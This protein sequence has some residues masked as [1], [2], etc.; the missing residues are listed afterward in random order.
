MSA[1]EK[2]K[3]FLSLDK[4]T[5]YTPAESYVQVGPGVST[6][7]SLRTRALRPLTC[8]CAEQETFYILQIFLTQY[9][10]STMWTNKG[11]L[12]K[13]WCWCRSCASRPASPVRAHLLE[14]LVCGRNWDGS[15]SE[16]VLTDEGKT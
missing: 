8:Q 3:G 9:S 15:I 10:G 4:N 6:M 2:A 12:E 14:E 13:E 5:V 11:I 16:S 1:S 7:D